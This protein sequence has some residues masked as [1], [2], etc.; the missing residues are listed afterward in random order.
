[1]TMNSRDVF[2][3]ATLL[4]LA[5]SFSALGNTN[6]VAGSESGY[7][8]RLYYGKEVKLS[9]PMI[10]TLYSNAVELLVTSNFNS[11]QP[12]G[13]SLFPN[14]KED[15]RLAVSGKY[16]L[17]SF[18]DIQ[19]IETIGGGVGVRK[20]IIALNENWGR[21]ELFTIDGENHTISHAKYSGPI[22]MKLLEVVKKVAN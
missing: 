17:I 7:S 6:Q 11:G 22:L 3:F 10:Q 8:V 15:Y 13:R 1:M 4:L 18:K 14:L 16:L 19:N 21:N 20:I 9:Q 5:G 2:S 12:A